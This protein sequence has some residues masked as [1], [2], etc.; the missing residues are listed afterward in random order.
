MKGQLG[1]YKRFISE[2]LDNGYCAKLFTDE[3]RLR[4]DLIIRH[5]IDFDVTYAKKI[6]MIENSLGIKSTFFFLLRSPFY[7]IMEKETFETINSIKDSG[8]EI[9]IHFDSSNYEDIESGV[10]YELS[11]FYDLFKVKPKIISVH[12]PDTIFIENKV[13]INNIAHT[14]EPRFFKEI[15][16]V[17]DSRG[18]F[19][20]GHP[21]DTKEYID[22]YSL[23]LCIHPIW[24]M[25]K[26]YTSV[27]DLIDDFLKRKSNRLKESMKQN[28]IPY[29]ELHK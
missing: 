1:N 17:S 23:H 2:F 13:K 12:R 8:H 15:K 18:S 21:F 6:A 10:K 24:W 28:F 16:Y 25:T 3:I 5:D 9:S 19:R 27:I 26:K 14:Y 7:N 11:L 29:Q 4:N 22:R 20:Y